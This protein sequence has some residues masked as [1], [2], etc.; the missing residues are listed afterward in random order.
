MNTDRNTFEEMTI[1]DQGMA[2]LTEGKHITQFIKGDQLLNLYSLNDFFVEVYYS[3]KTNQ[4]DKIEIVTD[5]SRLDVY[6]DESRKEEKANM[7]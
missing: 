1:A 3:L 5:L 4:I 7:N 2:L 6:I